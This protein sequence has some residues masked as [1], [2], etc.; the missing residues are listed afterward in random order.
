MNGV[1]LDLRQGLGHLGAD[2]RN[3][4]YPFKQALAGVARATGLAV[5]AGWSR[6]TAGARRVGLRGWLLYTARGDKVFVRFGRALWQR[7]Q[8]VNLRLFVARRLRRS[9]DR[10]LQFGDRC[11]R[12][13]TL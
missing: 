12:R 3:S 13:R 5:T 4:R 11:R 10:W 1:N 7:F 9:A 2:A 8:L 6:R